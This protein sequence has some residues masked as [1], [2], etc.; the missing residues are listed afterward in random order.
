MTSFYPKTNT[1]NI[2]L[3]IFLKMDPAAENEW[4]S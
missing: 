2:T 3:T 1:I 4:G